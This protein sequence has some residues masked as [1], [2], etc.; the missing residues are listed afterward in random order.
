MFKNIID[1]K[2][3]NLYSKDYSSSYSIREITK[4]LNINYSHTFKRI[5][6][7]VK[8]GILTKEKKGQ[9]NNITFN[10][11]NLEAVKLLSFVE[12]NKKIENPTLKLVIKEAINIDPFSCIGLFGSRVSG[13]AKK[14]SDWDVFIIT[15]KKKNMEK[16]GAKFPYA[17][18]I[19]FEVF[20]ID[21]FEDNLVAR[22]DTVVKHIV[23][24]KQILFN[25]YPFYNII[26]NW[27]MVKYAPTQ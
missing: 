4:I 6:E 22:E 26:N 7:L 19:H 1:F 15:A 5:N 17:K 3:L 11:K 13:G 21:E 10:I 14:D 18:N 27:E 20:S 23:R 12:E 16:I 9:A 2:I 25:P 24:N 8:E